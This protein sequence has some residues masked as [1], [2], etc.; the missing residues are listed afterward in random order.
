MIFSGDSVTQNHF[1]IKKYSRE[2]KI[3]NREKMIET[4]SGGTIS[5]NNMDTL[6]ISSSQKSGS[7][8]KYRH[9]SLSKER[10]R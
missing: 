9:N 2:D 8:D 4:L 5:N 1:S 6:K 10:I 3:D 7:L